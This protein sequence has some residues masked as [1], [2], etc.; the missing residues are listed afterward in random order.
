MGY[1]THMQVACSACT[2]TS[3]VVTWRSHDRH[4]QVA[5]QSHADHMQITCR[6]HGN[7][8][9]T[10]W[11]HDSLVTSWPQHGR[12][13]VPRYRPSHLSRPLA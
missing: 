5:R 7:H 1:G 8:I 9:Q 12:S 6:S 10:D 2:C 3:R 13:L 4:K 11:S